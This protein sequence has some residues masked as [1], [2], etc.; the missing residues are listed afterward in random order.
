MESKT[1][2]SKFYCLLKLNP[3]IIISLIEPRQQR[4]EE[5]VPDLSVRLIVFSIYLLLRSINKFFRLLRS[6]TCA[7]M[8][9]QSEHLRASHWGL[10]TPRFLAAMGKIASLTHILNGINRAITEGEIIKPNWEALARITNFTLRNLPIRT[11]RCNSHC[12]H[13]AGGCSY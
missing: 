13:F 3:R 12:R 1:E 11:H 2:D 4:R 5:W 9:L 7:R 10:L 8:V 6:L